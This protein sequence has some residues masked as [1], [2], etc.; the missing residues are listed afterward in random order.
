MPMQRFTDDTT[1]HK[2][3]IYPSIPVGYV[4]IPRSSLIPSCPYLRP[5]TRQRQLSSHIRASRSVGCS[6]IA[7]QIG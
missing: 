5:S 7:V 4:S 6:G 2:L 3:L 1:Y